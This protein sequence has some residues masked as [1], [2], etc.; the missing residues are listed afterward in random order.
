MRQKIFIFLIVLVFHLATAGLASAQ[1]APKPRAPNNAPADG[2]GTTPVDVCDGLAIGL[3]E[4]STT[5]P[6]DE[7]MVVLSENISSNG[8]AVPC[9]KVVEC[10]RKKTNE[11]DKKSGERVHN[12]AD[13]K[14][15]EIAILKERFPACIVSGKDGLD[16]L[17][18]YAK[19]VYQWIAGI[20]G[21]LCILI[22][23]VSGIQ[24][25]IGGL[26]QEEV[27]SAK[28]RIGRSLMGMVVLFLSAFILYSINP[29]F[30][31]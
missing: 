18:N 11:K 1:D 27:S 25:S 12:S 28:D 6:N 20:V 10:I 3:P 5:T 31:S 13:A 14:R 30:F 19:L 15:L 24:I 26:S 9:G 8:T 23:I 21:S 17:N 7:V 2:T 22:I 16:L 29:I 4:L